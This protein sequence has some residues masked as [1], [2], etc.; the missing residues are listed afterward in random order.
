MRSE[1][2][3]ED[4]EALLERLDGVAAARVVA[5]DAGDVDRIYVTATGV[6]DES[7]LRQEI[8]AALMS[9]YS[10]TVDGSRVHV[11]RLRTPS[12]RPRWYVQRVEETV[13]ASEVKVGVELQSD[14]GTVAALVGRSRGMTDAASRMR[15]A[16]LATLDA[17]KS[18]FEAED[19]RV[20][21]ESIVPV[22]LAAGAA[23]VVALSVA[24]PSAAHRYVGTA[25]V[26]GSEAEAVIAATLDALGKRSEGAA[27]HG[28]VRQ[29]R[30]QALEHLEDRFRRQRE[31]E[32]QMPPAG[33]VEPPMDSVVL[34]RQVQPAAPAVEEPGTENPE[35]EAPGG[36]GHLQATMQPT[37]ADDGVQDE[38]DATLDQIRPQSQR[39]APMGQPMNRMDLERRLQPKG[40]MEDDFFRHL[41]T[42]GVPVHI[43]C[44]EGYEIHGGVV[45]DFGTYSLLVE[46]DGGRELVFKHGI[47]SIRPQ[48]PVPPQE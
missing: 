16:A 10:L 45:K 5:T 19:R 9:Q 39:G 6:R 34:E 43:R 11:A 3:A 14:E 21:V 12:A 24:G 8:S 48:A 28:W 7:R 17:L 27:R 15:T 23:V 42:T 29:D 26:E 13:T 44:R 40:S 35:P 18:V 4:I 37:P 38:D 31:P 22:T 25:L 32:P 30:R 1:V 46:S 20:T 33:D 41:V 47:I 2:Y 36:E